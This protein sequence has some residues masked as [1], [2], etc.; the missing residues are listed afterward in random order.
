MGER[1]AELGR[2]TGI[3][4]CLVRHACGHDVRWSFFGGK[5]RAKHNMAIAELADC[6]RCEAGRVVKDDD[7][8]PLFVG[9]AIPEGGCDISWP[10]T[11]VCHAHDGPCP[12][13]PHDQLLHH[14][15]E[16]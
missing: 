16:R 4:H 12:D 5:L 15:L 11:G 6:P 2:P 10:A 13:S 9:P 1:V 14:R 3:V 8:F 7:G